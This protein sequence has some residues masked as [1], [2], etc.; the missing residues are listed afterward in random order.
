[1]VRYSNVLVLVFVVQVVIG[2]TFS[3]MWVFGVSLTVDMGF[4]TMTIIVV[5]DVTVGS[6]GLVKF[7]FALQMVTI[8]FFPLALD[9]MGM[10]VLDSIL[11]FV[12][13]VWAG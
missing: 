12:V 8:A 13:L 3:M 4:P 7:I 11:E 9:V 10:W 2:M 5:F 6:I 1:M